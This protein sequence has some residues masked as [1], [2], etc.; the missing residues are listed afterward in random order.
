MRSGAQTLTMLAAPLNAGILRAVAEGPKRQADL[1]HVTGVPAQT[2]LRA[3]LRKLCDAGVIEKQRRNRFPGV[4]EYELSDAGRDLLPVCATLERWLAASPH[5]EL[6]LGSAAAK[7]AVK[8]LTD[9]WSTTMLRAL[10][11]RSLTL[12][13]LDSVISSLNYPSLERRLSAMRLAGLIEACR[14]EGRGTPYRIAPWCRA[15]VAPLVLATRWER[16]HS[17]AGSPPV[18]KLD[19]ETA[20]LLATQ[21]LAPPAELSGSCRLAVDVGNDG[22]AAAAGILVSLREGQVVSCTTRLEGDPDAWASAPLAGWLAAVIERDHAALELGG[23]RAL[24]RRLV[25][26]LHGS[27]FA[28][29]ATRN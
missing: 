20:F 25:D 9:A 24:A 26:E 2:T 6:E 7:V 18:A 17:P 3:Q 13:E 22:G 11:A 5:G 12:T 14:G 15:G 23:D 21:L 16:R 27:L 29:R 8:A 1:L 10:A 28:S 19:V 4:L